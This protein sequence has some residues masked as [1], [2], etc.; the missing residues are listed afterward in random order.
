MSDR[1]KKIRNKY[2]ETFAEKQEE[3]KTAWGNKDVAHV[4]DLMHKLAGSSG[5]YGFS[6]LYNLVIHGME[7]TETHQEHNFEEIQKC[8]HKIETFLL[9]TY[10]SQRIN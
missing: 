4:H 10:K 1:F 2:I 5:G 8:L 3:I 6:D 7:L 9:N